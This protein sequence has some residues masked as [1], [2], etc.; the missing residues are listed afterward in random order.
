M[1]RILC[2]VQQGQTDRS[3]FRAIE[4]ALVGAYR[5]ALDSADRPLVVWMEVPAGQGF[6]ESRPSSMSWLMAEVDD[7]LDAAR[8]E[9]VLLAM[10]EAWSTAT[11]TRSDQLMLAVCDSS[12]FVRYQR[13]NAARVRPIARPL[14]LVR[15]AARLAWS[16]VRH[17][18]LSL[19]VNYRTS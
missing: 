2:M 11:G 17:G 16:R 1:S 8:R 18:Y 10:S 19:P 3:R 12:S 6:T 4:H 15:T 7:G 9:R 5:H 14:F 13:L